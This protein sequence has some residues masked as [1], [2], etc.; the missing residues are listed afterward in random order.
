MS[1]MKILLPT[2]FSN[3]AKMAVD[4]AF[5][6]FGLEAEYT[7]LNLYHEPHAAATSMISLVDIAMQDSR[8]SLMDEL[9]YFKDKYGDELKMGYLS[10]YGEGGRQISMLAHRYNQDVIIM[11][12]KGASG[13]KEVLVG[14]VASD[15][16]NKADKP[17]IVVPEG[18]NWAKPKKIAVAVDE[19]IQDHLFGTVRAFADLFKAQ[20]TFIRVNAEDMV[21]ANGADPDEVPDFVNDGEQ[22][23]EI[24][25]EDPV[26]GITDFTDQNDSDLLVMF[27]GSHGFLDRLFKRSHTGQV[28]MHCKIP[29]MTIHKS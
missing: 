9:A 10:E 5:E 11:G 6:L 20:I 26:K 24:V 23:T 19:N 14:S 28:A 29:L 21:A 17:V 1:A 22:H 15:T 8:R 27:P 25:A 7:L 3:N 16:I 4:F 2:D 12:T 18:E 13:L